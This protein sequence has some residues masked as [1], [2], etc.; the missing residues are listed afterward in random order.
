MVIKSE[1]F[2]FSKQTLTE[3]S[4]EV[5]TSYRLITNRPQTNE[6]LNFTRWTKIGP[7]PKQVEL[8]SNFRK[9]RNLSKEAVCSRIRKTIIVKQQFEKRIKHMA[10]R[11]AQSNA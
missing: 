3:H 5:I 1:K 7:G 11:T 6:I 10:M 2:K 4:S 9:I 8:G